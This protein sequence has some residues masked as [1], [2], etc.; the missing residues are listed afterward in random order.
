MKYKI[1]FIR[2]AFPAAEVLQDDYRKIIDSNWFT[3]FGPYE[4]QFSSGAAAYLG[5]ATYVTT[6]ANCTLGLD[7]AIA[8]LFDASK[9]KVIMPSFTFA[10]G[11]EML[12]RNGFT[13]VFIDIDD[14]TWQPDIEQAKEVIKNE[15]GAIA[16]I[17]L[18][19]IFGVGNECVDDWEKLANDYGIPLVID[20]AA[21]FGSEYRSGEKIGSRGDCEVFSL[22]ATK[23]F[24]VGEGGLIASKNPQL[25]EKLRSFQ[26]FGFQADRNIH[27]IGTNA[28]MQEINCAIGV[29]Q[30]ETYEE[31]L[32]N[33]RQ[34]LRQYKSA[35]SPKGFNFQQ[36][37]ELST[38][39]FASILAP[40]GAM[41]DKIFTHLTD[42]GIEVRRYYA[43]LHLQEGLREYVSIP[44]D[45]LKVTEDIASRMLSI[46]VHD[47]MSQSD[48]DYI[49]QVIVSVTEEE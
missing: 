26:N 48:I 29:R 30:L 6:I 36:N 8:V 19:N 7:A 25:I 10:A 14:A 20:S 3:N 46:P 1:P 42:C 37:D 44:P 5:G 18:C 11:P 2:P 24:A 27:L 35:L 12:I 33:R 17:L 32:E 40:T 49:V 28:K 21:G 9:S 43:P 4:K 22:H 47:R 39:P 45:P 34:T 16:G 15:A 31:R 13:P 41:A 38:V 23:P